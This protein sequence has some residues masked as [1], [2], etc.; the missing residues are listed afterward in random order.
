[1][2]QQPLVTWASAR[3]AWNEPSNI[4]GSPHNLPSRPD[5][6][7]PATPITDALTTRDPY[8]Y[9]SFTDISLTV[10]TASYKF[11]DAPIG[12]RDFLGFRNASTAAQIIYVGFGGAASA[13]SFLALTAGQMIVLDTVV[14]QDDLWVVSSAAGGILSYVYSTFA[15]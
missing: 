11:L 4:P 14:P 15:G 6:T 1:M 9:A 3:E 13:N 8:R 12:K 5:V 2:R 10:G 7:N